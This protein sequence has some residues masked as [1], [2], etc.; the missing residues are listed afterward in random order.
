MICPYGFNYFPLTAC[1]DY[2]PANALDYF[3]LLLVGYV[4]YNCVT[5]LLITGYYF[6]FLFNLIRVKNGKPWMKRLASI[7]PAEMA[8]AYVPDQLKRFLNPEV[9]P[10]CSLDGAAISFA[11]KHIRGKKHLNQQLNN[12]E[13]KLFSLSHRSKENLYDSHGNTD[14][15]AVCSACAKLRSFSV[16]SQSSPDQSDIILHEYSVFKHDLSIS[17][18]AF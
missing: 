9:P 16:H 8:C 11:S 5:L 12:R 18:I 6:I 1:G 15:C 7:Q 4:T 14:C 13:L 2:L 3:F 17:A 10:A